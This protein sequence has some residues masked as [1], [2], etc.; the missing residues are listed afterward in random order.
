[1]R[2]E[3]GDY[4]YR[5]S[6]RR[7][8]MM[9]TAILVAAIL[10]QVGAR[11]LAREQAAKNIL[12]VMAILTVLPM[13]NMASPLLAS[14]RY[15]TPPEEF[16]KKMTAYEKKCVILY[17]LI[18]TTKEFVLP[19]D[20]IAVHSSGVYAYCTAKK[21][22]PV[23]AE[24]SLNALLAANRLE[25]HVKVFKDEKSLFRR[26]DSLKEEQDPEKDGVTEYEIRVLK[27]LSM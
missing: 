10:V 4:G 7:M 8:R 13:A 2:K 20:S 14:W 18:L 16:H 12:T 15:R 22:D 23:R 27:S 5:D 21:V 26:L 1:M 3:K 25:P 17:D 9:I 11:F 6:S 19:M 24:Q